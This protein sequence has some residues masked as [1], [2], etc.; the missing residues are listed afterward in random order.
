MKISLFLIFIMIFACAKKEETPIVLS[1]PTQLIDVTAHKE[2]YQ[3]FNP[4]DWN[5]KVSNDGIWRIAGDWNGTGGTL[6]KSN[7]VLI[8]SMPGETTTGFLQLTQTKAG[9]NGTESGG[10]AQSLTAYGYGYY[11][12]RMKVANVPGVC[13]SFFLKERVPDVNPKYGP[14]EFDHEFLTNESWITNPNIGLDH[15]STHPLID[16]NFKHNLPFNPSGAFHRYGFLWQ[17]GKVDYTVDG[18]IVHTVNSALLNKPDMTMYIMLNNWSNGNK[19][20]GGG[21]PLQDATSIYDW[22][23]FTPNVTSVPK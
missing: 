20:W 14:Y 3:D 17:A 6:L 12:C 4:S 13:A 19:N 16:V 7:A 11:E 2:T 15:F 5:G 1:A 22:V 18:V 8:T 21:P 23:K 9:A 10:E